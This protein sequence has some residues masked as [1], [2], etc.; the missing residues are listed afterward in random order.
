MVQYIM[1]DYTLLRLHVLSHLVSYDDGESVSAAETIR[2]Y[3]HF[4]SHHR[5]PHFFCFEPSSRSAAALYENV[6]ESVRRG[7]ITNPA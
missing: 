6:E 3:T 1:F 4:R 5:F 2:F 7:E